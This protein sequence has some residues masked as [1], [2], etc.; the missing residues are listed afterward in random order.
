LIPVDPEYT[1]DFVSGYHGPF[2][3]SSYRHRGRKP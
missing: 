1:L 3:R 2:L